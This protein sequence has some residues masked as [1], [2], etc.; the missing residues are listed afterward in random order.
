MVKKSAGI[1]L[2]R[3]PGSRM[4][5]LLGHPGG[6]Y[7]DK[8]DE[9]AWSI[10]KGE[11]NDDEQPELA[12]R[13]ELEE[14]TGLKITNEMKP[15][16]PVKMKS[17][18]IIYAWAVEQDFNPDN[19]KSNFFEMEWP[20]KSGR[21]ASFPELDNVQWFTV[22]EAK[23]KINSGQVPFLNELLMLLT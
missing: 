12:A 11:F 21:I 22:D 9:G 3:N 16:S 6:P 18:K 5:V 1:L 10:P 14:E 15:L 20:P 7:W 17:G 4:E 2:F 13:R 23:I 8:K 19:F